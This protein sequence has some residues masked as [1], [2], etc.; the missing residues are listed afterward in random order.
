MADATEGTHVPGQAR[1][2][3]HDSDEET[4]PQGPTQRPAGQVEGDMMDPDKSAGI[5]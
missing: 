2:E 1:G 5:M 3:D 4:H